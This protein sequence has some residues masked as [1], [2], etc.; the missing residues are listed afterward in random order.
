MEPFKM[1]RREIRAGSV[2]RFRMKGGQ[3]DAGP[4]KAI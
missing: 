2:E 4:D 3:G 1:V